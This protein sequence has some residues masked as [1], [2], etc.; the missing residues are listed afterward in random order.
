MQTNVIDIIVYLARKI[1]TG[2]DIQ[3]IDHK[4]LQAY[5]KAEI[6]AAYSWII[7]KYGL[8]DMSSSSGAGAG[9]N[10]SNY[11]TEVSGEQSD[12]SE[13]DSYSTMEEIFDFNPYPLEDVLDKLE[14]A[15]PHRILHP[16]EEMIL[17]TESYG[18]LLELLHIGLINQDHLERIIERIMLHHDGQVKIGKLKQLI[19]EE[20]FGEGDLNKN[21]G[22]GN[23]T[24]DETIH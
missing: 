16:A 12:E 11:E 4:P 2:V 18:Y 3:D 7:Q 1:Y 24:G 13:W 19:V 21:S 14:H 5:N 20:V 23:L 17:S 6:G 10:S 8:S 9:N 15:H 22:S